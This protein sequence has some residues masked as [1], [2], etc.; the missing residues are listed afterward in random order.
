[1]KKKKEKAKEKEKVTVLHCAKFPLKEQTAEWDRQKKE[2]TITSTDHST[3][4]ELYH[5]GKV[6]TRYLVSRNFNRGMLPIYN[7]MKSVIDKSNAPVRKHSRPTFFKI[8]SS[9]RKKDVE[10]KFKTALNID[11]DKAYAVCLFNNK[12]IDKKTLTYL[13]R[14]RP[15]MKRMKAVGMMATRKS[16]V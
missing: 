8:D 3:I 5:R 12:F 6:N 4:I 11:I 1:M 13:C 10:Y 9:L 2:F 7:R 15:K 16:V 14:L